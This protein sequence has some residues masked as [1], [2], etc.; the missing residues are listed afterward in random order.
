MKREQPVEPRKWTAK[1]VGAVLRARRVELKMSREEVA[2]RAGVEYFTVQRSEAGRQM[3]RLEKFLAIA[4]VLQ[5]DVT[6]LFV[7]NSDHEVTL[8]YV[9]RGRLKTL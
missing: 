8:A 2:Y 4:Q 1:D 6:S 5:L 7:R 9:R 3:P